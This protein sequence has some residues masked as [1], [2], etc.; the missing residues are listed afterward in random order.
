MSGRWTRE[1][2]RIAVGVLAFAGWA[3]GRAAGVNHPFPHCA[4]VVVERVFFK[5]NSWYLLEESQYGVDSGERSDG[6]AL[7]VVERPSPGGGAADPGSPQRSLWR[8][9]YEWCRG[10]FH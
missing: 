8:R 2:F 6:A 5:H 9:L 1:D 3:S 7:S 10:R 4:A